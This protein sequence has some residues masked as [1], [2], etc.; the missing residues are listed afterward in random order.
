MSINIL[1]VTGN[2]GKDAVQKFT[3]SGDSIVSF[4]LPVRSG[5]GDKEKTAW[6]RCTMFGKRSE[7]VFPYLKKGT[8]VGV[9]GEF[10]MAEWTGGDGQKQTMPECRVSELTLLGGKPK[11]EA[12]REQ[13]AKLVDARPSQKPREAFDDMADD[14]PF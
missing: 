8:L 4:S 12:E 1:V 5:Y 3:A 9:S 13:P 14:V 11:G 10:S 2:L 7:G 6:V